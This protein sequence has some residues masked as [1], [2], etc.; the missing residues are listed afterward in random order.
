MYSVLS[1]KR[2]G[3][4]FYYELTDGDARFGGG[5]K[6]GELV[7][8]P[9]CT[10]KELML[11]TL[12]FRCMNAFVPQVKTRDVWGVDLSRFGFAREGDFFLSSWDRLRL[13]HDC[14][15]RG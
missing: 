1:G 11:R 15:E 9:A 12:V 5:M 2:E 4:A 3:Y 10:Q 14:E 6:D 13:P 8:D 7:C